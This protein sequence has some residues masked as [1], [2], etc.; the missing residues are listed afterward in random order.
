MNVS[1]KFYIISF[2]QKV[3]KPHQQ[4]IKFRNQIW[5]APVV[6]VQLSITKSCLTSET[7][8]LIFCMKIARQPP[9]GRHIVNLKVRR[10]RTIASAKGTPRKQRPCNARAVAIEDGILPCLRYYL[11]SCPLPPRLR[12]PLWTCT[13]ISVHRPRTSWPG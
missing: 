8:K 2:I 4:F 11:R 7:A 13:A 12:R 1:F 5:K 10:T 9:A 6:T 3:M